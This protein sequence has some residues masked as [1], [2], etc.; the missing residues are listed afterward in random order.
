MVAMLRQRK[1]RHNIPVMTV[2]TTILC[3]TPWG[4]LHAQLDQGSITGVIQDSTGAAI[5][6]AQVTLTNID[7][8]LTLRTRSDASGVY[9]FSPLKIGNYSVTA[10]ASGFKTTTQ[11]HIH[12]DAGRR[13]DV[14]I[15]LPPGAAAETVTVTTAPPILETQAP[16]V[17]QTIS[18][19]AINTTPLNGRNWV[20]I[21]QLTAGVDVARGSRGA[22]E[23]DFEANGQGAG[24]NNF[25]LDG[26]DNN[27]T[28]SDELGGTA[29]VVRPPPDALSEFTIETNSYS[30]EYGHSAGAVVN[31]SIKS[32]TNQI[33]GDLWEYIRNNDFDARDWDALTIPA[34][35]QNQFGGTLGLP[36]IKN[37]LFLF[38]DGEATRIV[39][40]QTYTE[41]VPTPLMR[42]GNFTELLNTSLTGNPQPVQLYEPGSGGT[43][44][45]S[46]NLQNNV[47]CPGKID[48]EA[49]KILNLYP[50]PNANNGRTYNNYV[51]T[52]NATDDR[53]AWDARMDWNISAKDQT[54]ARFSYDNEPDF[55]PPPLGAVLDGGS[56]QTDGTSKIL[57]DDFV[58]SET[59]VFSPT[60]V[61]EFRVSYQYSHYRY[62]GQD[63]NVN[64]AASL[65]FGGIPSNPG[66]YGL[67]TTN[68]SGLSR[69]GSVPY[70]TANEYQNT[71]QALDNLTKEMGNHSIKIGAQYQ[72]MRFT[73]LEP[74]YPNGG[75]TFNG[76][77][78]SN[79]GVSYTGYGVADFLT[80]QMA[81]ATISNTANEVNSRW[82]FGAYGQDDWRLSKNL[83]LNLGLR[84]EVFEPMKE[85]S[86]R[87]ANFDPDFAS[88]GIAIGTA[89][90][91]YP[92][93]QRSTYFSQNFLGA[94][95]QDNVGLKFVR[96]PAL[97]HAQ[98]T[99]FSP[100]VG[101]AYQAMKDTV[102]RGGF[103]IFYGGLENL[104][105]TPMLVSQYPFQFAS[106]FIAP[107]CIRGAGNCPT[108]GFTLENGFASVIGAGLLNDVVLPPLNGA[109]QTIPTPYVMSENLTVQHAFGDNYVA[110][111]SYVGSLGRH[112]LN[113]IGTNPPMALVNPAIN[114][115]TITP[116]PQ[117]G[118]GSFMAD[119]AVSSYNAFQAKL[120]KHL[121]QDGLNFLATYTWSHSLDD[122]PS[123]LGSTG[124]AGYRS[125]SLVPIILDYSSS[126]W[127]TRQRFTTNGLYQLPFGV[128]ARYLNRPG[129]GNLVAGGWS[130]SLT[131]VA[132]SGNPFT[133]TPDITTASGGG[134]RAIPILNPFRAGGTAPPSNSGVACAQATKT[135]T[136]WYNPCAFANPLAGSLISPG[137][138][139]EN[140]NDPGQPQAGYTYPEYVRS[141]PSVLQFLGGRRL[142][143]VDAGYN[144]VN[145]SLFK[146]FT[147]IREERLEFR[148]DA[149]N[150]LNTPSYG[151]PSVANDGS[152]GGQI[153][154]TRFF[155]NFTPDARFFQFSLKYVY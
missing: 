134:S 85:N 128:H 67:P 103:G 20:Y 143:A 149:F 105:G 18:S 140:N 154:S 87:Q 80:D 26:V 88:W 118:G 45:V 115:Q 64:N 16:T 28:A 70:Y 107:S 55:Y 119:S 144:R 32:G 6:N 130:T 1:L 14:V 139:G 109:P 73:T 145:M 122:A 112:V 40:G 84:Y 3:L 36:L 93:S 98:A 13:L 75:Y 8:G 10:S 108:N 11:E 60:L 57:G 30:A 151:D 66:E 65:G 92:D 21:A 133:V 12:L 79:P 94:L 58:F 86:G 61:N 39:F 17:A 152:N 110:T 47:L 9:T 116:Y 132:S 82:Y 72:N 131:F 15:A 148:V 153:T 34:Y 31:A 23:G 89:T 135:R 101:F 100:R 33:H 63:A 7:T 62:A 77:Y 43:L 150:L 78:T 129:F 19:E 44:P 97:A 5:P 126:P 95:S 56:F 142:N 51:Q 113:F 69:F 29:Y 83:T 27:S 35:H 22:G 123:A 74:S 117:L 24:Q 2:L 96:Y 104:G 76:T 91:Y 4:Y 102:L 125:T 114:T 71:Y 38:S 138:G 99:N 37:K 146:D 120:E 127:D 111:A 106:N 53:W 52:A 50:L 48:P 59:H 147:T 136:H 41:T 54:F 90:Y 137:P 81:S 25:V 68:I 155:Q 42:Q 141:L 121:T 124:D 46:C 49:Q